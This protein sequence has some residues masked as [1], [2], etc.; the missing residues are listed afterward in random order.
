MINFLLI[1][2]FLLLGG[3]AQY[4]LSSVVPR[5][6]QLSFD[7]LSRYLNRYVIT[8]CLPSVVLLRTPLMNVDKSLLIPALIP[9]FLILMAVIIILFVSKIFNWSRPTTGCLLMIG[10]FGNT[11]FFGF[12]V[13]DAFYGEFALTYAVIFDLFGSFLSLAIVGN[14]IIAIYS[15]DEKFSLVDTVSRVI[16]FPPFIAI[17]VAFLIRGI[18]YPPEITQLLTLI[19]KTLVPAAMLLVG[20]HMSFRIRK[21]LLGSLIFGVTLKLIILPSLAMV[22]LWIILQPTLFYSLIVTT[23]IFESAM[24]PMV[25]ACVMAIHGNL[26]PRLAATA[27]GIGLMFSIVSLPL[28]F[29]FLS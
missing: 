19:V 28:W 1:G 29:L 13:V 23:T 21:N 12:P 6:K 2:V 3:L 25:T 22:A 14:I 24:P 11:S 9:W 4:H 15:G 16:S 17:L 10:C 27:V 8:I 20:M 5:S 18:E 7:N 26:N